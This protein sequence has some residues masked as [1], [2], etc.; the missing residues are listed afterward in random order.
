MKIMSRKWMMWVLLILGAMIV[1][2]CAVS[3]ETMM[4]Y[5]EAKETFRRPRLPMRRNAH[6]VNMPRLKAYLAQ[7]DHEMPELLRT[8]VLSSE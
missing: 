4:A 2:G 6:P 3:K 8:K 5:N 7:A 1:S